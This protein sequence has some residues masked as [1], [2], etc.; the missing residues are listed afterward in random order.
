[1]V[2]NSREEWLTLASSLILDEIIRPRIEVRESLDVRVGMG[3]IPDTRTTGKTEGA[4]LPSFR[5]EAGFNELYISPL[6]NDSLR[7]LEI[8]AHEL[9]HAVDDCKSNH[10]GL[11]A[12]AAHAIGLLRP[13][14]ETHASAELKNELASIFDLLGEIPHSKVTPAE[15]KQRNRNV[16][17]VCD[18]H[19]CGFKFNTSRTQI[20]RI[21]NANDG[22]LP[23]LVCGGC[24][25]S[26]ICE[27][28]DE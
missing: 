3:F 18:D 24:M 19:K 23:C 11:F 21:R 26:D 20:A 22:D 25:V 10:G 15:P 1:M 12:K 28:G 16:R 13:L 8:L 14:N 27:E 17:V 9:C 7:C 4:C 5:S 6:I 2:I